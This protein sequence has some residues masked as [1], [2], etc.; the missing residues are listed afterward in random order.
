MSMDPLYTDCLRELEQVKAERDELLAERAQ[1]VSGLR[2]A[3][4]ERDEQGA[5]TERL[6]NAV[7]RWRRQELSELGLAIEANEWYEGSSPTSLAGLK[8]QW[9]TEAVA[10]AAEAGVLRDYALD[11]E[12][13]AVGLTALAET[14]RSKSESMGLPRAVEEDES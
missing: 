3:E 11:V 1:L 5:P 12:D 13:L 2:V 8:A 10:S 4:Q 14:I 6:R 9:Q 7:L